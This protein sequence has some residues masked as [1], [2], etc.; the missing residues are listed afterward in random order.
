MMMDTTEQTLAKWI[1]L[2]IQSHPA[3]PLLFLSGAQGIGKSTALQ[4]IQ[5]HYQNRLAILG[6]DDFYLTLAERRRLAEA[7]DPL[8]A[9]RGPPGTHDL[10]FLNETISALRQSDA[11]SRTAIPEFDKRMDDRAPQNDWTIFEG[12]PLAILV[13]GWCVGALPVDLSAAVSE[14]LNAVEASDR[15]GA[16]RQHQNDQLAGPYTD[17]WDR[18]DAFFHLSAPS[19]E[20][21]LDWRI[22]QE[23]TTLGLAEGQLPSER[24][25]WVE[26]FIQHY[27]RLTRHMLRGGRRPGYTLRVD[28]A[29]RPVARKHTPLIVF[30]DLDGTLLDH[31][32]YCFEAARPALQRLKETGSLLV[33]ASSK[34]ASEIDEL[35]EQMGFSH[36]PAIVENGPG[37]LGPGQ[38]PASLGDAAYQEIRSILA[39][40]PEALREKFE[41][42]GDCSAEQVARMTGLTVAAARRAKKRSFS[43]PGLWTGSPEAL[44]SFFD[45]LRAAGLVPRR[46]GRF[47]TLSFGA[48]KADQMFSLMSQYK[49]APSLALGDA[50]NDIEMLQ[51]AHY[52][53][54]IKNRHGPG[55]TEPGQARGGHIA[56]SQAEGPVGWNEAVLGIIQKLGINQYQGQEE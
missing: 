23:E 41:G 40:M 3:I 33:L 46:G 19:F 25:A 56:R 32:T 42:F 18:A 20:R 6:L 51:A 2:H 48:T 36:C 45:T 37:Y 29:R 39:D 28:A 12:R 14:P 24:R 35:R 26:T 30:S 52:G 27:E 11:Q 31:Q 16:W 9:V 10:G 22:Q 7:I 38:S 5:K 13:E 15:S 1:D 21:V 49:P 53:V 43:E 34:T 47:L 17:L 54:I 4:N 8:F 50:P 55:I 44:Q